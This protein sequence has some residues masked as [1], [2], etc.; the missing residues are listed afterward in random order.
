ML[1]RVSRRTCWPRLAATRRVEASDA[2]VPSAWRP[3]SID[4]HA[5]YGW[6]ADRRPECPLRAVVSASRLAG[7]FDHIR[8]GVS[9]GLVVTRRDRDRHQPGSRWMGVDGGTVYLPKGTSVLVRARLSS[10]ASILSRSRFDR[11]VHRHDLGG[12]G[13]PR[14]G[15]CRTPRRAPGLAGCASHP[16]RAPCVAGSAESQAGPVARP[17]NFRCLAVTGEQ[18]AVG[19]A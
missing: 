10:E 13:G 15:S 14:K 11:L 12:R 3:N 6:H 7:A 9:A 4:A 19:E 17:T 16:W 1:W 18:H 2:Q 5:R 8:F